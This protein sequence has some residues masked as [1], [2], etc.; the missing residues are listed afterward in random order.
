MKLPFSHKC[1]NTFTCGRVLI[2]Y[3]LNTGRVPQTAER[4]RKPP[5][6]RIGRKIKRK[7]RK[8]SGWDLH[9][10]EGAVEEE[11]FLH[12]GKPP[13]QRDL[14]RQKG[15]LRASKEN[16]AARGEEKLHRWSWWQPETP[17]CWCGQGG[18]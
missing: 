7:M 5:G 16:A 6:N 14:P 17:V 8:E 3:L 9:P 10:W 18:Y 15:S 12:P 4:A 2:E 11:G 1:K 13:H